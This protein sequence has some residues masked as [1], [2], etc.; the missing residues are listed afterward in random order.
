MGQ[1]NLKKKN[2]AW[3]L[4]S[5]SSSSKT[6]LQGLKMSVQGSLKCHYRVPI[7]FFF[8]FFSV[9]YSSIIQKLSFKQKTQFLDNQFSKQG[10]FPNQFGKWDKMLD[11]FFFFERGICPFWPLQ[12]SFILFFIV[13]RAKKSYYLPSICLLGQIS[14]V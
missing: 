10:H 5:W 14:R 2:F 7:F 3:N 11:F 6:P 9:C 1:L 13:K 4:S 12:F 8:F